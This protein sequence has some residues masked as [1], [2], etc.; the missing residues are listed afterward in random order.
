MV[1]AA[2]AAVVGRGYLARHRLADAALGLPPRPG[3][4]LAS[5]SPHDYPS[6]ES[7]APRL[8]VVRAPKPTDLAIDAVL[9]ATLLADTMPHPVVTL[10][11]LRTPTSADEQVYAAVDAERQEQAVIDLT[12]RPYS[13]RHTA[14]HTA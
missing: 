10:L 14:R 7:I 13:A 9:T 1:A 2:I 3:V 11:P 12:G 6:R 8:S 4:A 5:A